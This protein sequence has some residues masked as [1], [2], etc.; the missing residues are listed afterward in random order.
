MRASVPGLVKNKAVVSLRVADGEV[1]TGDVTDSDVPPSWSV[2]VII[3]LGPTVLAN[4]VEYGDTQ[5]VL[6]LVPRSSRSV[7]PVLGLSDSVV[8]IRDIPVSTVL[9]ITKVSSPV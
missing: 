8:L 7:F 5:G 3:S 6:V 1:A 4:G 9:A 2:L